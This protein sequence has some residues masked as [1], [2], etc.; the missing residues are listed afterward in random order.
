MKI[1]RTLTLA[2]AVVAGSAAVSS[3]ATTVVDFDDLVGGG[4]VADGYG[5]INWGGEWS[6]YDSPQFP[7]TPKSDFTRIFTTGNAVGAAFSFLQDV[8]FDGAWFSGFDIETITFDLWLNGASVATASSS[9]LSDIPTFLASGYSGLVDQVFVSGSDS[10]G[11]S[12]GFYVMDDVTYTTDVA[13]IPVPAAAWL[14][15]SGLGG[16]AVLR[17]GRKA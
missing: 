7:Y 8:V 4:I 11:I 10:L 9:P 13:P 6:Y 3:A 16:L 1:L 15:L 5:G 12:L 14:L 17:R 2:G